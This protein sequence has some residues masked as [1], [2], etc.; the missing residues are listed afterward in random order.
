MP[1]FMKTTRPDGENGGSPLVRLPG[2]GDLVAFG[3][4][5]KP[6]RLLEM[7]RS[8]V[9]P[10]YEESSPILWWSP[11]PRAILELDRVHVSRSL[12]RTL[13]REPFRIT[14]DQAFP[15]V[16]RACAE[17]REDDDGTWI[18]RDMILAYTEMHR[19]GQGPVIE[20][21]SV[22]PRTPCPAGNEPT[23]VIGNLLMGGEPDVALVAHVLDQRSNG[24]RTGWPPSH[25]RMPYTNP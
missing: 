21:Q 6:E 14:F 23:H 3:G 19:L 7:Y 4:D 15:E 25:R 11:D 9:F 17:Q 24:Q 1:G 13:R 18:T 10:W 2:G 5:L 22:D 20:R 16:I 12:R 8:G